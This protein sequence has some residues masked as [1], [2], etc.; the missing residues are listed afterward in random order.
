ML[1][2]EV[3]NY[4]NTV[5][6]YHMI[7]ASGATSTLWQ[8]IDE[9]C[10]NIDELCTHLPFG[11]TNE[12]YDNLFT[13]GSDGEPQVPHTANAPLR[14]Y[15]DA[16]LNGELTAAPDYPDST[17]ML[18]ALS[19]PTAEDL[20]PWAPETP[21]ENEWPVTYSLP[22]PDQSPTSDQA[23]VSSYA[24]SQLSI[25]TASHYVALEDAYQH[26][27]NTLNNP[28]SGLP[29][30]QSPSHHS[31]PSHTPTSTIS[32]TTRPTALPPTAFTQD[33][34]NPFQ[35]LRR[36]PYYER[37]QYWDNSTDQD[38]NSPRPETIDPMEG[39][40]TARSTPITHQSA[41]TASTPMSTEPDSSAD[42][43]QAQN[44]FNAQYNAT[45]TASDISDARLTMV[46]VRASEDE[47]PPGADTPHRMHLSPFNSPR[48]QPKAAPS[49]RSFL[50]QR[51]DN[52]WRVQQ[53][54]DAH[55][56]ASMRSTTVNMP[57][58]N[59]AAPKGKGKGKQ[60]PRILSTQPSDGMAGMAVTGARADRRQQQ[61]DADNAVRAA[62][63]R[64]T[65]ES[66][67]NARARQDR[68]D[69]E[70]EMNLQIALRR[71]ARSD[72]DPESV[73]PHT[74]S[75][76]HHWEQ[77]EMDVDDEHQPPQPDPVVPPQ[78]PEATPSLSSDQPEQ[79]PS[80]EAP[81]DSDSLA[82]HHPHIPP[83]PPPERPPTLEEFAE[84]I[85]QDELEAQ[86]NRN[87]QTPSDNESWLLPYLGQE[88]SPMVDTSPS[89]NRLVPIFEAQ[90]PLLEIVPQPIHE[91]NAN[92]PP[93]PEQPPGT[94]PPPHRPDHPRTP[95][96]SNSHGPTEENAESET[97]VSSS[98]SSTPFERES[99]RPL[100]PPD[101]RDME[102]VRLRNMRD[103][104]IS[105]GMPHESVAKISRSLAALEAEQLWDQWVDEI[106]SHP[107]WHEPMTP[108]TA[109]HH[110]WTAPNCPPQPPPPIGSTPNPSGQEHLWHCEVRPIS[111]RAREEY[112][113]QRHPRYPGWSAGPADWSADDA[114]PARPHPHDPLPDGTTQA[115]LNWEIQLEAQVRWEAHLR[116]LHA[117]QP[118]PDSPMYEPTSPAPSSP[119]SEHHTSD[120][121]MVNNTD[122]TDPNNATSDSDESQMSNP[123]HPPTA[124]TPRPRTPDTDNEL[125]SAPHTPTDTSTSFPSPPQTPRHLPTTSSNGASSSH[126]DAP[127]NITRQTTPRQTPS[128]S[129]VAPHPSSSTNGP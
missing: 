31:T 117:E 5:A 76:S 18:R 119:N 88:P 104:W 85:R 103:E 78:Q 41:P 65:Q 26:M 97:P 47:A 59:A 57:P 20:R 84:L 8:E 99:T 123:N 108:Q 24:P 70:N 125:H 55:Y 45:S 32:G 95:S 3:R 54:C 69:R 98:E 77:Y 71:S 51:A 12:E 67:S 89:P 36:S 14:I 23:S 86:A 72:E 96:P 39:P 38:T 81:S 110:L 111:R 35:L 16:L 114:L 7:L 29:R 53:E 43:Q 22:T 33:P 11:L 83:S 28:P 27:T 120:N 121:D 17:V 80:P 19:A 44:T 52:I 87:P 2:A 4:H 73:I 61:R 34:L 91:N 1:T 128:L 10:N 6:R 79:H 46:L 129:T 116:Q 82:P 90:E 93:A 118:L 42:E 115:Q 63:E 50:Q 60:R 94:P 21:S 30:S 40:S 68:I 107:E 25:H 124:L 62:A 48:P 102:I 56:P 127:R 74:S 126:L 9:I 109:F 37:M 13:L 49:P 106:P 105:K 15:A 100:F 64:N 113:W 75:S 66:I 101:L 112:N 122:T 92:Q 58:P